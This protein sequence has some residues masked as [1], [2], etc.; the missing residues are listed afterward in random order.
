MDFYGTATS[1]RAYHAARGRDVTAQD[2]DQIEIA[3][4]VASEWL[5]G[6]FEW[7]GY[8]VGTRETQTRSWPR[9]H[10]QDVDGWPVNHLV[11]P[12]EIEQA[13][14]EVANRWIAEP[15]VLTPDYTP[16]KYK[17]VS[18]DGALTVEYRGLDAAQVQKQFPILGVIL[19]RLT[20]G[21]NAS[22]LSSSMVRV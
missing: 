18:I 8:K 13:T 10:V 9:S 15:T 11:V 3:L 6:M 20:G 12:V 19:A 17:R 5:D 2:D 4:L 22:S 1:Y 7:P 14:Y 21:S 16:E